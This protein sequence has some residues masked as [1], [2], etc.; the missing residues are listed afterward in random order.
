MSDILIVIDYQH[1]FVD[2][3]LGS[4]EA[5]Q[6]YLPLKR[7]VESYIADKKNIIFTVDTHDGSKYADTQEGR[8]LPIKH[9]IK[10]SNGWQLY[11]DFKV[12]A[13]NNRGYVHLAEKKTFGS[14]DLAK[15]VKSACGGAP[16]EIILAGVVTDICVI[17]NAVL[18]KTAFSEATIK[19]AGNLCAGTTPEMHEKALAVMTSLQI[20][21][22][23]Q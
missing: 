16:N 17:A 15:S 6:L 10:D 11:G 3:V 18:L 22:V 2:G 21:V 1:D 23:K 9:C 12:L 19:V 13:D 4:K 5:Q 14:L 8:K 20:E 7:L